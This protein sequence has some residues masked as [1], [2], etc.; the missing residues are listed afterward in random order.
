MQLI[1]K[2]VKYSTK[3]LGWNERRIV[4]LGVKANLSDNPY[5][6]HYAQLTPDSLKLSFVKY[7]TT[8]EPCVN[9][10]LPGISKN[11]MFAG[12]RTAVDVAIRTAKVTGF[13]LKIISFSGPLT[14]SDSKAIKSLI[15]KDFKFPENRVAILPPTKL[16]DIYVNISDI[17]IA[18]YWTTAHALDV[19]SRL[20]RIDK[21]R[22]IYLIQDYEPT[23]LPASTD[24]FIASSTYHAGFIPLVNSSPLCKTLQDAEN[25]EVDSRRVFT[26]QLDLPRLKESALIRA[27]TP[28]DRH[29]LFYARPNKPRNMFNLGISSMQRAISILPRES[30]WKFS[31]VGAELPR[32]HLGSSHYLEPLGLLA[33]DNY[34]KELS[35]SRVIFSLQAS[36]HPSHP[37]LDMVASGGIAVT[38]EVSGTR[39]ALHERLIAVRA[40]P[41]VLGKALAQA[42]LKSMESKKTNDFDERFISVLGNNLDDVIDFTL[43]TILD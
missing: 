17:W 37:P 4:A 6:A 16:Q 2:I 40:D 39:N 5:A 35:R 23:F 33:W 43:K 19:A 38:N 25:L 18:T 34:F 9:L 21:S 12:I 26:P 36:P 10:V 11:G 32:I 13:K 31:S 30:T 20:N 42:V 24:S 15:A 14:N 22:I 3:T 27:S 29:V 41:D 7:N 1:N 28:E 8:D